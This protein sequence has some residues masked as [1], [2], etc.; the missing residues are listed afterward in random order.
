MIDVIEGNGKIKI[1]PDIIILE[2]YVGTT[3]KRT[4]N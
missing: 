1:K 3:P 2:G 4:K